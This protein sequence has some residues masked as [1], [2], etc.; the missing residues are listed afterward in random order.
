MIDDDKIIFDKILG[1]VNLNHYNLSKVTETWEARLLDTGRSYPHFR[2]GD[3]ITFFTRESINNMT[4]SKENLSL[5]EKHARQGRI[6]YLYP[7][8]SRIAFN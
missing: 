6:E 1:V 7:V 2:D 4:V 5:I 3:K 8:E